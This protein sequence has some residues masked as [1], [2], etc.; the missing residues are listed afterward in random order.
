V[1]RLKRITDLFVEGTELNLGDDET[2]TPVLVWVNKL[3]SFEDEEARNDGLA[4][5]TEKVLSLG[6]EHPEIKMVR[7]HM[8]TWSKD[9]LVDFSVQQKFDEDYLAAMDDV[10]GMEEWRDKLLYLR[11]GG[12]LHNDAS[13][14]EDDPRRESYE[15][16]QAEYFTTMK[17]MADKRQED[18]RKEYAELSQGEL[19]EQYMDLVKNR[20]AMEVFLEERRITEIYFAARDCQGTR[21][22]PNE[23]EHSKCDHRKRLMSDR[24]EVRSLP[25][26]VITRIVETIAEVTVDRRTAGNSDAPVTSSE[27]SEQPK[28]AEE[29]PLSTQE[30]T[31]P[32]V[33]ST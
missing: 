32:V 13:L 16:T 12:T 7:M 19:E 21:I 9:K 5:R 22:G 8:T 3:N 10:D 11:R 20:L 1:D 2:G 25:S 18:R 6:D 24:K 27:S 26:N 17:E 4:A 31:A 30:V 33:V 14:P 28:Q 15:K 29:Q 23:F